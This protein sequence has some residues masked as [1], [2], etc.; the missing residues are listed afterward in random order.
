MNQVLFQASNK[1]TTI[2]VVLLLRVLQLPLRR[3][4][5]TGRLVD[6]G[7]IAKEDK[8]GL[9]TA[10][11]GYYTLCCF[12]TLQLLASYVCTVFFKHILPFLFISPLCL[13]RKPR[14][15]DLDL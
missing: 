9:S 7:V 2:L 4:Q 8:M 1:S 5:G 12:G 13:T 14:T 11:V 15:Q 10:L 3:L 6:V